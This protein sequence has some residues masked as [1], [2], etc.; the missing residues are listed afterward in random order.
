LDSKLLTK[1]KQT[2][3][4]IGNIYHILPAV[5]LHSVC[6]N[7]LFNHNAIKNRQHADYSEAGIQRVRAIKMLGNYPLHDYVCTFINPQNKMS[8][9]YQKE[10]RSFV[11]VEFLTETLTDY[12]WF[13][14]KGNA[15][16]KKAEF[17]YKDQ[18]TIEPSLIRQI[19]NRDSQDF[20]LKMSEILL[21]T[22]RIHPRYI[23]RIILHSDEIVEA[24][25]PLTERGFQFDIDHNYQFYCRV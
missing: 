19:K 14:S 5:N 25:Y 18:T 6:L 17:F 15:A 12:N 20:D 4:N 23:S 9:R 22:N 24:Y 16:S 8:Y 3:N 2:W 21:F 1:T 7:G 13:F 11:I 10:H